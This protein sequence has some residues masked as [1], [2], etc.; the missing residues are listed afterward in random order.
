MAFSESTKDAAFK[1]SGGRCECRRG[2][3]THWPTG[4]RCHEIITRYG[5][6]YHHITSIVADGSDGLGNCQALCVDCYRQIES[7]KG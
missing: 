7:D 5:A 6:V 1:R 2:S 4:G 3:H